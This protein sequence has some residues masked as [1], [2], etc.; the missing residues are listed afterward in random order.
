MAPGFVRRMYAAVKP[1]LFV[2]AI[3]TKH[4]DPA[5]FQVFP[6]GLIHS[7]VFPVKKASPGGRKNYDSC[8]CM[9]PNY[10]LHVAVEGR[11]V[12]FVIL[13]MHLII[14]PGLPDLAGNCI[15]GVYGA[16]CGDN[17]FVS[18]Y[19]IYFVLGRSIPRKT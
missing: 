16:I 5:I 6:Y 17:I 11:T 7:P 10:K 14:A 4:L 1:A 3:D 19:T 13:S 2:D 18:S 8:P 9:A 15:T 12:P